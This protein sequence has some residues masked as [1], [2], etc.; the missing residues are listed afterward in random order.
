LITPYLDRFFH[1]FPGAQN[2]YFHWLR[3]CYGGLQLHENWKRWQ[4]FKIYHISSKK[5]YRT[6]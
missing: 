1:I 5:F 4:C 3:S 2:I 6:L